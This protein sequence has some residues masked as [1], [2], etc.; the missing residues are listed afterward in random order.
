MKATN[1]I[2]VTL[3]YRVWGA[4]SALFAVKS[5]SLCDSIIRGKIQEKTVRGRGWEGGRGFG[6]KLGNV[7]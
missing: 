2:R 7:K 3:E 4:K 1:I 6:V 5:L